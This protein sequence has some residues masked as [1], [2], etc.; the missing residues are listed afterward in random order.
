MKRY[1]DNRY[2]IIK[3]LIDS[4]HIKT[5]RDVFT[6]I[7]KT[8]VY[9]DLGVNFKKFDRAINDPSIFRKPSSSIT[10]GTAWAENWS[11]A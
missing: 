6:F 1:K 2:N 3:A 8:T 4:G 11:S 7:P 10:A 5:F 9:K